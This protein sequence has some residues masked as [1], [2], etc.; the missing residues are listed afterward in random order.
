MKKEERVLILNFDEVN[1]IFM[2][3]FIYSQYSYHKYNTDN[4][5]KKKIAYFIFNS[6]KV[7]QQA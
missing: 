5:F 3:Y 7:I 2:N 4:I 6:V 1:E